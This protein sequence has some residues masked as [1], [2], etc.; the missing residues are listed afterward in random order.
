M[1]PVLT[2]VI[3]LAVLPVAGLANPGLQV[4]NMILIANASPGEVLALKWQ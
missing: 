3:L 1:V 4:S 2:T